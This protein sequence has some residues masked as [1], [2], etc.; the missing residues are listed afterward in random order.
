[1]K[2]LLFIGYSLFLL[3]LTVFSYAFIDQHFIFFQN[4]YS[5]FAFTK[6]LLTTN[7]YIVSIVI[8]FCFYLLFLYLT[9]KKKLNFYHIKLL[10]SIT[11]FILFFSYPAMLSYDIFNYGATAKVLFHYHENPYIIM[12]IEFHGDPLL[13]F[14]HAANKIALYGPFWIILTGIPYFLSFGSFTLFLFNIKLFTA[15]SYIGTLFF[16]WKISKNVF[17]LVFFSLNPL[18]VIETLISSH[19]DIVMVF[20]ALFSYYLL[21]QKK[22]FFSVFLLFFSM[23]IKYATLF[24]V[25]VYFFIFLRRV[26]NKKIHWEN[27]F[28]MSFI[29][30]LMVFFLAPFREEIYPWYEIWFLVFASLIPQRIFVSLFSLFLS[31]GLMFRYIPFMLLGTYF[32]AAPVIKL[33]VTVIPVIFSIVVFVLLRFVRKNGKN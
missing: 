9:I 29:A 19:N 13:L 10:I 4:L 31:F 5:G 12:P 27:I 8:F 15:L 16:I 20:L 17:S 28:F 14:T 32:G 18:V 1:M 22:Y 30:M 7:L 25:P 21:F 11:V 3:L 6:R 26:T 2:K 33:L 23:L 24:L